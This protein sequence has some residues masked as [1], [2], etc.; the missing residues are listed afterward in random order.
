MFLKSNK[1]YFIHHTSLHRALQATRYTLDSLL[2]KLGRQGAFLLP[3]LLCYTQWKVCKIFIHLL[4]GTVKTSRQRTYS[5]CHPDWTQKWLPSGLE[6]SWLLGRKTAGCIFCLVPLPMSGHTVCPGMNG[7]SSSFYSGSKVNVE[8]QLPFLP[9]ND[10]PF[11]SVL[12]FPPLWWREIKLIE[13]FVVLIPA[14]QQ[15]L[16]DLCSVTYFSKCVKFKKNKC[17]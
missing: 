5:C 10:L 12:S 6:R 11:I 2:L 14:A 16:I 4:T 7:E 9:S 17:S 15:K 1:K 8:S 3:I 13:N